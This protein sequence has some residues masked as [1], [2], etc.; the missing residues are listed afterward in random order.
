M[1]RVSGD[2]DGEGGGLEPEGAVSHRSAAHAKPLML[3]M[4]TGT[5]VLT[6]GTKCGA[7][8]A[9]DV[10]GTPMVGLGQSVEH[11]ARVRVRVRVGVRVR[12]RGKGGR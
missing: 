1:V 9:S 3:L 12:V 4:S 6:A 11:L 5:G 7:L 2:G 8:H 10:S